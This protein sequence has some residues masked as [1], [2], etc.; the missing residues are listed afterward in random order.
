MRRLFA[1]SLPIFSALLVSGAVLAAEKSSKTPTFGVLSA[2]TEAVAREQA[3]QWLRDAGK[4]DAASLKSFDTI[5]AQQETR[6]LDKVAATFALGDADA[7]K[8]LAEARD[9]NA[10]APLEVP[11]LVKNAKST[12]FKANFAVAYARALSNRKIYEES[13]ETLKLVKPEQTIDPASFL[14]HKAVAEHALMLKKDA[15]DSIVRL[16]DD[17]ADAPDRYKLVAALM[18]FDMT[19]WKDKDLGW[20]ARKMDNIQRRLD[21]TRGGDTTKKM[22]K[23]VVMRLDE[24]IKQ[25]ENQN[26]C[27]CDCN[28]GGCPSD[29]Q[30]KPGNNPNN[31]TQASSPQNDSNRGNGSGPGQVDPKKIKELAEVWGKLP[32]RER[33][34]AMLDL[35]R[36]MPPRYRVVI[37][38]YFRKLSQMESASNR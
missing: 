15:D 33:A 37:E 26:K 1:W 11:S 13:L 25:L 17:V 20:I 12:F 3:A 36:D 2:P 16:L 8:L 23:E 35:T 4:T 18:H 27:D 6:L 24:L 30:S 9:P 19:S 34:R 7:A 22:Q 31:N 5:W 14:F 21:L 10:P 28:S 38:D 29:G 32:E